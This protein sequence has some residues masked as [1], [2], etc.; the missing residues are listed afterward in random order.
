MAKH[1]DI[2]GDDASGYGVNLHDYDPDDPSDSPTADG[3]TS[4]H[5]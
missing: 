4:K 5:H 1:L 2:F 3:N